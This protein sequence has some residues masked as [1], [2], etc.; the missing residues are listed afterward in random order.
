[1]IIELK[2][3]IGFKLAV[4]SGITRLPSAVK[5]EIVVKAIEDIAPVRNNAPP[6]FAGVSISA[7]AFFIARAIRTAPIPIS[8]AAAPNKI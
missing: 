1:M 5:N 2:S 4:V 3:V 6:R 7:E 8:K